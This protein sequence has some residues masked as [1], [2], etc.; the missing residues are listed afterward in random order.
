MKELSCSGCCDIEAKKII[1][2][3]FD[4]SIEVFSF[5]IFHEFFH[6]IKSFNEDYLVTLAYEDFSNIRENKKNK[7]ISLEKMKLILKEEYDADCYAIK[8]MKKYNLNTT[9]FY[10]LANAYALKIKYMCQTL[11][12]YEPLSVELKH[13]VDDKKMNRKQLFDKLSK[14]TII[15]IS[16]T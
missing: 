7:S 4:F 13:L 2:T 8:E 12:N 16:S 5:I 6:F 9:G 1:T 14:E 11:Q 15:S 10:Q 3:D